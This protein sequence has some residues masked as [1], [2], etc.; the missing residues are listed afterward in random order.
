MLSVRIARGGL[1]KDRH[2]M[3]EQ[4]YAERS[5][6]LIPRAANKISGLP[7]TETPHLPH[8]STGSAKNGSVHNEVRMLGSINHT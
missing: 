7:A 1:S 8:P 5:R 4:E 6:V 3:K 2:R